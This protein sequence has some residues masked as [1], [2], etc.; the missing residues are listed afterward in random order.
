MSKKESSSATKLL[1]EES[2]EYTADDAGE[3]YK[4]QDTPVTK[5][6]TPVAPSESEG[7]SI[8]FEGET[9]DLEDTEDLTNLTKKMVQ[10]LESKIS[11]RMNKFSLMTNNELLLSELYEK[12][13]DL[14]RNRGNAKEIIEIGSQID[15][16]EKVKEEQ[17]ISAEDIEDTVENISLIIS[18]LEKFKL[19]LAKK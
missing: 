18:V 2:E 9:L 5:E 12:L 15:Q 10:L 1:S 8:S 4:P 7:F 6:T 19:L 13:A 14:S 17:F 3:I 11:E 16:V